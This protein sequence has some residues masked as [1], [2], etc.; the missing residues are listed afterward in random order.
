MLQR[1]TQSASVGV[2]GLILALV[3]VAVLPAQAARTTIS[4]TTPLGPYPSLPVAAN[5]LDC[6]MAAA[7]T[8]N[9]NQFTLDG[10]VMIIA[11]NTDAVD[12]TI[13]FTSAVDPQNRSGDISAYTLSADEIAVF[14]VDQVAGWRQTDGFFY[15]QASN[16]AVKFCVVRQ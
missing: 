11:Q 3:V 6:T 14:K 16:A 13:T 4:R 5:A 12:R 9:N 15:L 2:I 8:V 7:D 1:Y 10:P